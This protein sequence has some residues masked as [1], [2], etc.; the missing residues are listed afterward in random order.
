M[1]LKVFDVNIYQVIPHPTKC[2]IYADFDITNERRKGN[3]L[4]V[5]RPSQRKHNYI[6]NIW[7][8]RPH[9]NMALIKD[10]AIEFKIK[11]NRD[12]E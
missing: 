2:I 5:R 4:S 10:Q 3:L 11:V 1:Y 7:V 9:E 12:R 6:N 8:P